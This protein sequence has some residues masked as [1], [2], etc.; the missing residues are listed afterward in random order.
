[1]ISALKHTHDQN[2]CEHNAVGHKHSCTM[3]GQ[4][5][6]DGHLTL[7]ARQQSDV[8]M[9]HGMLL[10]GTPAEGG[11]VGDVHIAGVGLAG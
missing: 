3:R 9:S 11:I 4:C 8:V 7:L 1:M 10:H 6:L 2:T 5:V